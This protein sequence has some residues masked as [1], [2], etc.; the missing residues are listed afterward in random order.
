MTSAADATEVLPQA[1][2]LDM[3][4]G[5]ALEAPEWLRDKSPHGEFTPEPKIEDLREG[6][7][8][9]GLDLQGRL[10]A[11]MS[12]T[13]RAPLRKGYTRVFQDGSQWE[14][15]RVTLNDYPHP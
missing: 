12:K 2:L 4:E 13:L 3:P 14:L 7:S 5:M 10:C 8:E 15:K 9:G 6:S 11:S 1:V